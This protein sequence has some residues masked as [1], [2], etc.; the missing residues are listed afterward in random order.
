[1]DLL[2]ID[3]SYGEGGGQIVRTAL[4]LSTLTQRPIR[5]FNIRKGRKNSGLKNQHIAAIEVLKQ[6]CDAESNDIDVGSEELIYRPKNIKCRRLE[7]DIGTA[8]SISLLMQAITLP[9]LFGNRKTE[10]V[11]KGGTSG[12]GQMPID[13]F[14][15]IYLHIL[16]RYCRDI[17]VK[18]YKR[19][20]FP[21]GGGEVLVNIK[22]R[23]KIN[24]YKNFEEL[25]KDISEN[26]QGISFHH[27]GILSQIKGISHASSVLMKSE[28]A[29]RQARS[30]EITL[31]KLQVP[32]SIINEYRDTLSIGSGISLF[33]KFTING[34][35]AISLGA[36]SYGELRKSAEEVG[37]EA[38][39]NLIE[40]INSNAPV[41][42]HLADN[43][44]PLLIFGGSF[45]TSR[46]TEH[47]KTNVWVVNKFFPNS[48]IIEGNLVKFVKI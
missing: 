47:T 29:E 24:K 25:R 40:E 11:I 37:K 42:S 10:L 43:L 8:G 35:V 5:I 44:V 45:M 1:M 18:L 26:V 36:S 32:V 14:Q 41:D 13:Y 30:A 39:L 46:I 31:K 12:L 7:V 33:A 3:G 28:V 2:E 38:A 21:K 19:G 23:F 9:L 16:N 17:S 6:L 22:P 48:L 34:D 4:A 15:N 20:Y 27:Q